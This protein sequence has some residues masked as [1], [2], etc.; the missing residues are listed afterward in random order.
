MWI[1]NIKMS[2]FQEKWNLV[3]IR[4]MSKMMTSEII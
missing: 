4:N 2:I 3:E 1:K